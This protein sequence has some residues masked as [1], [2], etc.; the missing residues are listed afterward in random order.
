MIAAGHGAAFLGSLHDD[1]GAIDVAGQH[2]TALVDQA[3]GRFGFL[4]RQ[5][6]VTGKDH[7]GSDLRIY[8]SR[9]QGKGVDV[10]QH[11][12]Y[13]LGGDKTEFL[14]LAGKA[15]DHTVEV[16]TFIDV[17]KEAASIG[18]VHA[19]G[20]QAA[21]VGE[22]HIRKALSHLDDVRVEVTEGGRENQG[23]AVLTDHR[24]HGFLHRHRLRHVLFFNHDHIRQ[25][26]DDGSR[27]GMRLVVAKVVPRTNVDKTNHQRLVGGACK[28]ERHC[29]SH[30]N[31]SGQFQ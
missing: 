11:L 27:F 10:A 12:R 19:L 22:V 20:P 28:A 13:R 14:G 18:R 29:R 30:A 31:Q 5:G 1:L 17:T 7:G 24:F 2:V 23:S 4:D 9:A 21:T 3:V 6:P 16:L 25:R 15:S 8:R 26:L